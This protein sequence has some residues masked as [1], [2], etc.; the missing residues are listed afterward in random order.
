VVEKS[1]WKFTKN[2]DIKFSIFIQTYFTVLGTLTHFFLS[3]QTKVEK[4]KKCSK[5]K[6]HQTP[7]SWL[8]VAQKFPQFSRLN[9]FQNH[10]FPLPRRPQTFLSNIVA[11]A[12]ASKTQTDT[13]IR[14]NVTDESNDLQRPSRWIW[15]RR[16][17]WPAMTTDWTVN[18][19]TKVTRPLATIVQ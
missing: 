17:T 9:E 13:K 5:S 7:R 12:V 15:R 18:Q 19:C 14:D 8:T 1:G 16:L 3:S 10:R 2:V 6:Q 4:L 11:N